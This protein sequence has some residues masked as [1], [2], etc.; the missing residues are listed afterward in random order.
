[1]L[2]THICP[3]FVSKRPIFKALRDFSWAKTRHHGLQYGSKQL[4]G[5]P[6][7]LDHFWK[8]VFFTHYGPCFGPKTACFQRILGFLD[9]QTGCLRMPSGPGQLW[10]N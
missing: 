8:N 9:V 7:L 4:F 5:Y 6:T 1:M 2:F 3:I 10:K